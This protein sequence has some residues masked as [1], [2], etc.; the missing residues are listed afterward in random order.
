MYIKKNINKQK[1]L[2]IRKNSCVSYIVLIT[3]MIEIKVE[4]FF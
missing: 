4:E 1:D 3:V 2:V